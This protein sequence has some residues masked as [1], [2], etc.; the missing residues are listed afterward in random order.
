V[1]TRCV[2]VERPCV[3]AILTV[4]CPAV[5]PAQSA[6]TIVF[7]DGA[8]VYIQFPSALAQSEAPPNEARLV[9]LR[10]NDS[11]SLDSS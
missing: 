3:E 11:L 6:G 5:D 8:K 4:G 7:D 1:S 9:F 2:H 10:A